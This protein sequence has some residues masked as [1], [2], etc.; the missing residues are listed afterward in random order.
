MPFDARL[1]YADTDVLARGVGKEFGH[2][3]ADVVVVAA[4]NAGE[5]SCFARLVDDV[6]LINVTKE[7]VK[8]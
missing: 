1:R 3:E 7:A 6:R 2:G 5:A 4:D 8:D